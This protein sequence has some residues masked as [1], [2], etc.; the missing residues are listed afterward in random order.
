MHSMMHSWNVIVLCREEKKYFF[1]FLI[2]FFVYQEKVQT[3]N[4]LFK[5]FVRHYMFW[6]L[7]RPGYLTIMYSIIFLRPLEKCSVLPLNLENFRIDFGNILSIDFLVIS[8]IQNNQCPVTGTHFA[9]Y[10]RVWY[11][12][13]CMVQPVPY[14]NTR[15]VQL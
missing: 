13:V 6:V 3:Q 2:R 5:L 1:K 15:C 9:R 14:G 11:L 8:R 4:G 10:G 12:Q 7:Y